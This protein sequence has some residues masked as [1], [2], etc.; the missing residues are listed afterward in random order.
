MPGKSF[1]SKFLKNRKLSRFFII[2]V[3]LYTCWFMVYEFFIK[4][5]TPVNEKLISNLV[6]VSSKIISLFADQIYFSTEDL[7]MQ[8]V[9]I[10]GAHPVWI[11]GPCNGV[12]IMV[13]FAIFIIAFPG[14]WK[15]KLW[16]VPSGM[17]VIHLINALR[18]VALAFIQFYAPN[19]LDFNHNYT[20]TI[21]VYA[22]IFGF[23]MIWVNKFSD[24]HA[25]HE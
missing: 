4:Y 23:W 3:S 1:L 11:G 22:I 21:L 20:F 10:D 16:F 2:A 7:E 14:P 24:L 25:K 9:G 6:W 8:M 15:Q 19:Y 12:S 13:L 17:L 5:H 18:I